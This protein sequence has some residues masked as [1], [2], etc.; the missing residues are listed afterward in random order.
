MDLRSRSAHKRWLL[1]TG[2][3]VG[4]FGPV[5]SLGTQAAT[6]EAAR[7]SLDLLAWPLDGAEQY[8]DGA[9]RFL[10]A[11]TGGFLFGWGVMIL[12]LRQWV[13]DAAPDQTR[14]AV[15]VG[16]VAWCVLDSLGSLAAGVPS[17]VLFNGLVLLTAAG[18]LWFR[19]QNP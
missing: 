1:V 4:S 8:V 15:L 13:Y 14:R 2:I 12:A 11:L 17:N 18:P 16:L 10:T 5:F 7:W 19:A 9:M 3:V 6:D